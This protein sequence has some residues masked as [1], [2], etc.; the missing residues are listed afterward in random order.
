M[1]GILRQGHVGAG[2][3]RDAPAHFRG[4]VSRAGPAPTEK[5]ILRHDDACE[6][7][8]NPG[9]KWEEL[10]AIG[11]SATRR[12]CTPGFRSLPVVVIKGQGVCFARRRSRQRMR[13]QYSEAV[14]DAKAVRRLWGVGRLLVVG[15]R[16][17]I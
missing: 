3:A 8:L 15:S 12:T 10:G 9:F 7:T 4:K 2:L 5:Y 14:P 16:F 17:L 6:T 13:V 1:C 11:L